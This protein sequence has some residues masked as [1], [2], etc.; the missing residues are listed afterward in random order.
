MC[1]LCVPNVLV[2]YLTYGTDFTATFQVTSLDTDLAL[3]TRLQGQDGEKRVGEGKAD[4]GVGGGGEFVADQQVAGGGESG[5][6]NLLMCV[7]YRVD[8]KRLLYAA[9]ERIRRM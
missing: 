6:G 5:M 7:R 3:L 1:T 9:I 8:R 2:P 4:R